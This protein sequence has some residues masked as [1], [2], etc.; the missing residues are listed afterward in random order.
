VN[1]GEF[2]S[3]NVGVIISEKGLYQMQKV[4]AENDF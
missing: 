3:G 2:V 4:D 1:A